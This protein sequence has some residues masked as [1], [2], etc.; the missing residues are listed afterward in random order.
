MDRQLLRSQLERHEG[1][2]LRPYRDIVGKLTIGF[3]RN[4]DDIGITRDEA[5]AML[6]NDIDQAELNL[7]TVD[8]YNTLDPIRQ[9]VLANMC[10]NL[11]FRGLMGFRNLWRAIGRQDWHSAAR[12]MLDSKWAVQVGR[13]AQELAAIMR[14]GE[15]P[16]D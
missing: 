3:G 7:R 12:E 14:S 10:F 8:E 16:R 15:A 4:L 2:R 11:G 13:R 5:M 9:T 1:L 6:D